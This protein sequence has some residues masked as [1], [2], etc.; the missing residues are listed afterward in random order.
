MAGLQRCQR[1]TENERQ[2]VSDSPLHFRPVKSVSFKT[3]DGRRLKHELNHTPLQVWVDVPSQG[4]RRAY[5]DQSRIP[6]EPGLQSALYQRSRPTKNWISL[7]KNLPRPTV[8]RS[9][10]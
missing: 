6:I 3:V 2:C 4:K 5:Q 7:K 9:L 8:A 1:C 10:I